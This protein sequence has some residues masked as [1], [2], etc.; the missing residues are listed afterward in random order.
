M[1]LLEQ[2]E[3]KLRQIWQDYQRNLKDEA[4]SKRLLSQYRDLYA[5]LKK[6]RLFIEGVRG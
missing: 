2:M 6:Q 3:L 4:K 1:S 5:S